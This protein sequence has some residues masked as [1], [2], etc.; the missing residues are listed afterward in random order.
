MGG[1]FHKLVNCEST[2]ISNITC[3]KNLRIKVDADTTKPLP[4]IFFNNQGRW[5]SW[6]HMR[7]EK[8]ADICY[9]CRIL[10]H[11]IRNCNAKE[12]V[13][14]KVIGALWIL[15]VEVDSSLLF[16]DI[17]LLRLVENIRNE[18]FW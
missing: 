2:T 18:F 14:V 9:K 8:L 3:I 16:N 15:D 17:G 5:G 12:V 13:S 7:Y 6:V 4:I 11:Q 10:G 1:L